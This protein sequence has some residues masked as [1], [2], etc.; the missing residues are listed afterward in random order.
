M[1]NDA[2]QFPDWSR[3]SAGE[4]ITLHT[5]RDAAKNLAVSNGEPDCKMHRNSTVMVLYGLADLLSD[6][7]GIKIELATMREAYTGFTKSLGAVAVK[8]VEMETGALHPKFSIPA[9]R[10]GVAA[11]KMLCWTLMVMGVLATIW[12][13]KGWL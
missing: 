3:L 4:R 12:K 2:Q 1:S 7:A 6:T 11:I 10:M 8:E 13:A 5:L 9:T